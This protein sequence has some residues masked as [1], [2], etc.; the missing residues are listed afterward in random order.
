[1]TP[2]PIREFVFGKVATR[3]RYEVGDDVRIGGLKGP[4]GDTQERHHG[5]EPDAL[6]AVSVRVVTHQTKG[7]GRSQRRHIGDKSVLPLLFRPRQSRLQDGL[8]ANAGETAVF[9]ELIDMNG[10]DNG[11]R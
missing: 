9:A 6:A 7:V 11:P 10:V 4:A 3:E 2:D 5:K 1:M 8:A